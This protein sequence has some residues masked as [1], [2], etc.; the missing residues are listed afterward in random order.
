MLSLLLLPGL[1]CNAE[2]WRDQLP[3]LAALPGVARVTVSDVHQRC[4]N[5][6]E[7]ARTLLAEQPGRHVLVGAS[8]GGMLAL[9][10]QRQAPQQVQALAL[11]GSSP[12]PDT[13]EQLR[14]RSDAIGLFEAGRMEELLQANVL[15]AFHPESTGL[16]GRAQMLRRYLAMVMA[17]GAE[18]LIAQNRAVMARVDSRPHLPA[19]ACPALVLCGEADLLTPP[20][21][22]HD[23]VAPGSGIPG[24]RL[25]LVPGAGHMLTMEQP[26]AVNRLL[27]D[28]IATL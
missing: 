10:M 15:F 24:A 1:A 19:V 26:E 7:M 9:E 2:L 4:T 14:L 3:A 8:M 23:F 11:L 18:Q 25:A 27:M 21:H 13:P 12:R 5:L 20:D 16:H 6:P 22:S 17:G 28:W